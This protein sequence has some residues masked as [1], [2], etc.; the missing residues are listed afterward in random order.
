[1]TYKTH[2]TEEEI[3]R[4]L[5]KNIRDT[6][7]AQLLT[8]RMQVSVRVAVR[9]VFVSA[10]FFIWYKH[11]TG[12]TSAQTAQSAAAAELPAASPTAV[13]TSSRA[14]YGHLKHK[15]AFVHILDKLDSCV[16]DNHQILQ[17]AYDLLSLYVHKTEE[18]N[19]DSTEND[20]KDLLYKSVEIIESLEL[21]E[22]QIGLAHHKKFMKYIK[23]LEDEMKT[24]FDESKEIAVNV[25]IADFELQNH[26]H[27][28]HFA[29][30]HFGSAS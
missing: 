24:M 9:I 27:E 2:L 5:I 16:G 22:F 30:G 29:G 17:E 18:I 26:P 14:S 12:L 28:D 4:V 6:Y 19:A 13:T 21:V 10:V 8:V 3:Y 25:Q 23:K 11:E 15:Q 7:S 1:M 20:L